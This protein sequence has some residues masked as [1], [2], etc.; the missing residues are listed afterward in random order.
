MAIL[1][2]TSRPYKFTWT[3]ASKYGYT[4]SKLKTLKSLYIFHIDISYKDMLRFS[5]ERLL[6][7]VYNFIK[8]NRYCSGVY[9]FD[10]NQLNQSNQT[11][12]FIC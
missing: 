4:C 1:T 10:S 6:N 2:K 11:N 9:S 12:H 3:Y 7:Y 5:L 8:F